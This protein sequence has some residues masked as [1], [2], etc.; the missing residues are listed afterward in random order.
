MWSVGFKVQDFELKVQGTGFRVS[1]FGFRFSDF[2][3]RVS[4]RVHDLGFEVSGLGF[5]GREP[6]DRRACAPH[7]P[8]GDTQVSFKGY[9][10]H[11]KTLPHRT[12]P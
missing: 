9:L 12:L 1:G 4:G 11:K 3:S 5:M 10:T 6:R 7:A 2:G 8:A